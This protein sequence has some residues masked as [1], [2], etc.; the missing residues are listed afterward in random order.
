MRLQ[1]KTALVTGAS[2][3]IGR[4]TALAL[5]RCDVRLLLTGR[6]AGALAEIS[7]LTGAATYPADLTDRGAPQRIAQWA[8]E[9]GPPQI[10]VHNAG[11]GLA[12]SAEQTTEDDLNRVFTVNVTAPIKLTRLLLPGLRGQGGAQ[13]VFVTSI[14]ALVGVAD[15]A[16]YAASK[17]ALHIYAA[18]LRSELAPDAV[19]VTTFAPGVVATPFFERRQTPYRRR[20]PRPVSAERVAGALVAAIRHDRLDVVHPLWLRIPVCLQAAAPAVYHRI[21]RRWR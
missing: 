21:R 2:S 5:A 19:L 11:T 4:A 18:S 10:V 8:T 16:A 7:A 14:A 20:F 13:L 3:G 9:L 6:D 17:A 1:G 12:R 15:E